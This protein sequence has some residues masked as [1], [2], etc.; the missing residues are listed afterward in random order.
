MSSTGTVYRIVVR[1]E[2][3]G[4]FAAAFEGMEMETKGGRTILTGVVNLTSPIST[5]SSTA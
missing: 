3:S 5:A 4:R 1:D 2:L